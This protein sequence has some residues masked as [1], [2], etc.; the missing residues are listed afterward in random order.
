MYHL[1]IYSQLSNPYIQIVNVRTAEVWDFENETLTS[2]PEQYTDTV[3]VLEKNEL[4]NGFPI[5]LPTNLLG[6]GDYDL[7]IKD[8][9]TPL[10]TDP[11]KRGKRI[12][13]NGRGLS[14][15][16]NRLLQH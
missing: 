16:Y 7:L 9:A 13:W 5:E 14:D 15:P 8:S 11:V 2:S 6:Y 10:A 3:Q 12:K 4:F 1:I